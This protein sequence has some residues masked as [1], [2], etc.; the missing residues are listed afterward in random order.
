MGV[1]SA[2]QISNPPNSGFGYSFIDVSGGRLACI[3]TEEP[4]C[5]IHIVI[6]CLWAEFWFH[7]IPFGGK[8]YPVCYLNR[9]SW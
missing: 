5:K 1:I 9:V 8:F 3:F 6:D 2:G 4:W 7:F